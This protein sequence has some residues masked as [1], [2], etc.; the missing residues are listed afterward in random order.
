[1]AIVLK[2]L[3]QKIKYLKNILFHILF[4][5]MFIYKV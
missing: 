2:E 5:V 4:I 1:M 3:I